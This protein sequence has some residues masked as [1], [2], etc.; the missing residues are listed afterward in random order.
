[1]TN[2]LINVVELATYL[3]EQDLEQFYS[4]TDVYD[5]SDEDVVKYTDEGQE[6]FDEL[7]DKYYSIILNCR[8]HDNT[9]Y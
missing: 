4:A 1:M 6:I 3:A 5:T 8:T 9:N 7:Y 2:Q